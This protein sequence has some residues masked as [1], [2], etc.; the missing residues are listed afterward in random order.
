M[1]PFLEPGEQ[2]T[3][4]Q[5][6]PIS[7]QASSGQ[8]GPAR[9]AKAK[10][11][12]NSDGTP[13]PSQFNDPVWWAKRIGSATVIIA[14]A[15]VAV[16]GKSWFGPAEQAAKAPPKVVKKKAERLPQPLQVSNAKIRDAK[17]DVLPHEII[18][19]QPTV[20][21]IQRGELA[22]LPSDGNSLQQLPKQSDGYWKLYV[23]PTPSL[24]AP[25]PQRI[26][27]GRRG[28]VYYSTD[29]GKNFV[30]VRDEL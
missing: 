19:L 3:A 12:V 15:L 6:Q 22:P 10:R 4:Q 21:R 14:L 16:K 13:R 24:P 28:E 29:S 1:N 9:P 11:A 2:P 23:H 5:S 30:K 25:G 7:G 17:G 20:D 18:Y 27:L 26:V 8:R